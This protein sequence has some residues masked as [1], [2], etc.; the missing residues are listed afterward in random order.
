MR[1]WTRS[2]HLG[3]RFLLLL[4]TRTSGLPGPL[5]YGFSFPRS[6]SLGSDPSVV[7]KR[8]TGKQDWARFSQG[9]RIFPAPDRNLRKTLSHEE[10]S[11]RNQRTPMDG[12]AAFYT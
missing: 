10:L 9:D 1:L 6:G 2:N 7:G 12:K 4:H 5:Y 11:Q 8:R 3:A